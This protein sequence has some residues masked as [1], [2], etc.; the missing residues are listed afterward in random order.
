M[1]ILEISMDLLQ[2]RMVQAIIDQGVA[3]HDLGLVLMSGGRMVLFAFLGLIGGMGC[4]FYAVLAAQG[5]GADMRRSL[6]AKVQSFSFANLDQWETGTLITRLTNDVSQFQETVMLILRMMVR[7]PI[8]LIGSLIM[9]I[10]TSPQLAPVFVA[11]MPLLLGFLVWIVNRMYPIFSQVQAR[12][13]RVNSVMQENLAGV[14]VVKAFSRFR[15]EIERFAN[16]N[17]ALTELNIVAARVGSLTMPTVMLSM[18]VGVVLVLWY[19]GNLVATGGLS[20]GKVVAF[21]NYLTQALMSLMMTSM[22]VIRLSRAEAS[23]ERIEKLLNA[24]PTIEDVPDAVDSVPGDGRIE[25]ENVT[26]GY[27]EADEPV[28]TGVSFVAEPGQTVAILGSTGA[29][30]SSLVSLIPRFYDVTSGR[31]TLNGID[32][33]SISQDALRREVGMALQETFLFSGTVRE[34]IAY[35][36]IEATDE[37]VLDAAR[38]AQ[39]DEFVQRL[40]EA[41]D[42]EVEQRGANFSGGQR[43]RLAIARALAPEPRVLILDDSTSA[44]DLRTEALI[45]GALKHRRQTKIVVAQRISAVRNA[46]KI[47]V[48]DDGR[49][50]AQGT[51]S[52]LMESSAVYREIFDSQQG[53]GT[54]DEIGA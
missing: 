46:D 36:C 4:T 21:V 8:L 18:N 38:A 42:S 25:F 49:L 12:L 11:L 24:E 23:S 3:R 29:G 14:R 28:L 19:G 6:F 34:N 22:L 52:E 39:A 48:L 37:Q 13:D 15:Y 53:S 32:V 26:F 31:V 1:M 50:V 47:L 17:N 33:R 5:A 45:T 20:V 16:A 7:A 51:H 41:Y 30:K 43:Q 10:L 54:V 44:V 9:A 27:G 2:P 40:P 35:G